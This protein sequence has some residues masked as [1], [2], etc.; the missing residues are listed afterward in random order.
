MYILQ[1]SFIEVSIL[2]FHPG[3]RDAA[4]DSLIVWA[5]KPFAQVGITL[6]VPVVYRFIYLSGLGVY[7]QEFLGGSIHPPERYNSG[8]LVFC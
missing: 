2:C 8:V 1:P 5:T 3:S 7:S 6:N 4:L